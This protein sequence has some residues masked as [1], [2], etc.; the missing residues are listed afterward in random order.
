MTE[1]TEGGFIPLVNFLPEGGQDFENTCFIAVV[2]NLRQVLPPVMEVIRE[3]KHTWESFVRFCR[4]QIVDEKLALKFGSEDGNGQHDATELLG[5]IVPADPTGSGSG[6]QISKRR[7]VFCCNDAFTKE[8]FQAML[9]LMFPPDKKEYKLKE[10]LEVYQDPEQFPDLECSLCGEKSEGTFARII[11]TGLNGKMV[12]RIGRY[13]ENGKRND[14]LI[15]DSE[16]STE[17]G[18][19]YKLEAILEHEGS[20]V[21]SGHYYIYLLIKGRWE[22]RNDHLQTFYDEAGGPLR[23]NPENV[24]LVVY[25]EVSAA[26]PAV[27][28]DAVPP[29][30][31][32]GQSIGN[33][34]SGYSSNL[35]SI[36]QNEAE[37][38]NRALRLSMVDT[39]WDLKEVRSIVQD[40]NDDLERAKQLSLEAQCARYSSENSIPCCAVKD[41]LGE[42]TEEDKS[43]VLLSEDGTLNASFDVR[44]FGTMKAT[45]KQQESESLKKKEQENNNEDGG[46]SDIACPSRE[47]AQSETS[48]TCCVNLH[49][50]TKNQCSRTG[51]EHSSDISS[52]NLHREEEHAASSAPAKVFVSSRK[53]I[54][55]AKINPSTTEWTSNSDSRDLLSQKKPTKDTSTDEE[56]SESKFGSSVSAQEEDEDLELLTVGVEANRTWEATMEDRDMDRYESLAQK[57]IREDPL[58]PPCLTFDAEIMRHEGLNLPLVH[59]A[60]NGCSWTSDVRPCL[61]S[62]T[63]AKSFPF[64]TEA[65]CWV[66]QVRRIQTDD[67]IYGCC[68]ER[69]CL[70]QHIV[71]AHSAALI[72]SCGLEQETLH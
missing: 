28:I 45:E 52:Q 30:L 15:L 44:S 7:V 29:Q 31:S 46:T 64:V 50:V 23:Y 26:D 24:Y 20:T 25:G 36:E 34:S 47:S 57:H 19:N 67:G 13:S 1:L 8:E 49:N 14:R 17:D 37:D 10:L 22:K 33:D 41:S 61:R 42:E 58:C 4:T 39:P 63:A 27:E 56:G 62:A 48:N 65:G 72:E 66:P 54:K 3:K 38:T 16:I 53:G 70:K 12:F 32:H 11:R 43:S 69:S 51:Q 18:S 6:V 60:F 59:C 35:A 55:K 9:P 71:D 40:E 21:S 2:A 5:A 68:D